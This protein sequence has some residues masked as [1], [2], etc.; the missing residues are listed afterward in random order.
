MSDNPW[1]YADAAERAQVYVSL[2]DSFQRR[3]E[4]TRRIEWLVNGALWAGILLAAIKAPTDAACLIRAAS[5]CVI[6]LI[7]ITVGLAHWLL[8]M[9]PMH[10]SQSYARTC[11]DAYMVLALDALHGG[12]DAELLQKWRNRTTAPRPE[13][14][15][16]QLPQ[17]ADTLLKG[18]RYAAYQS[19]VTAVLSGATLTYVKLVVNVTAASCYRS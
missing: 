14:I 2:R 19:L 1:A 8:W 16:N 18:A 4:S 7:V 10:S 5:P 12:R 9:W 6:F 15:R 11:A 17:P 3:R 13:E